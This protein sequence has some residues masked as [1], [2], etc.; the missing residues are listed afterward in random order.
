MA[1]EPVTAGG[2]QQRYGPGYFRGEG[3]GFSSAGYET[4]HA[5][6]RDW[7]DFVRDEVGPGAL[8][9]DVGCAYGFL[10][11]EA[12]QAGFRCVGID[13]SRWATRQG[14]QVQRAAAAAER[15][16]ANGVSAG[17]PAQH[18]PQGPTARQGGALACAWAEELPFGAAR[19][20][21]VSAFDVLEHLPDPQR[22]LD[23]IA[24]VLRTGGLLLAA[25]PDPLRFDRHEPSHLAEAPPA[26][27]VRRLEERG[28]V[29]AHR[30]RQAPFNL[31]LIARRGGTR[32]RVAWDALGVAEGLFELRGDPALRASLRQGFETPAA[33]D[34]SRL[35][36]D[37]AEVHLLNAGREPL[38]VGLVIEGEGLA[39]GE[40]HLGGR[41]LGRA[42]EE[43]RFLLPSGGHGLVLRSRGTWIR[44]R[45]VRF[46]S[47]AVTCAEACRTLPFDL[48]ERYGL[49]AALV[50]R[51]A[52]EAVALLDV[53]G[54]MS[55]EA[56]HLGHVE[57]FV[58]QVDVQS[59]DTR[60][61]DHARHGRME[62]GEGLPFA[63]QAF[64][65]VCSLDVL[66]HVPPQLRDD[67]LGEL[68]R[69]T[70][71]LLVVGA[72]FDTEGVAA[73]DAWLHRLILERYGYGAPFLEEHLNLGLPGIET[74]RAALERKGAA[75]AVVASGWL[76]LWRLGQELSATLSHPVQDRRW[77]GAMQRFNG[78]LPLAPGGEPAYRHIL[79]AHRTRPIAQAALRA[80]FDP[81]RAPDLAEF[82]AILEASPGG[83]DDRCGA[84]GPGT[85]AGS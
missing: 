13:A 60:W 50:E 70:R 31:E 46:E 73:A 82:R 6:F 59:I 77:V 65:V 15:S 9:L 45:K 74:A 56:G 67:W 55:A 71:G 4:V 10:V 11:S 29:V 85:E 17:G 37:G 43:I 30:F 68:W 32:P 25:T 26:V 84:T 8:W 24:R 33:A 57:D 48:F 36:G 14:R 27:W 23:E 34:N 51:W 21:V 38:E 76:P 16:A 79:V 78:L 40:I 83:A 75:P 69:V 44:L 52:P 42:D 47:R 18:L 2:F 20:A 54:A 63:D 41:C 28:F 12:C 62:P 49:M 5:S 72:P 61:I 3:S 1:D 39:V 53:G 58:P 19:F 7:M 22:A 35:A 81:W 66:E 64:D 80:S